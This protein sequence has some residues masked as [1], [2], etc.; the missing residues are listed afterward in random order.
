MKHSVQIYSI[1][2]AGDFDTQLALLRK[3]GFEWVE[4]VATHGLAP[5][6]FAAKLQQYGLK[7]SSMHASLGLV[8]NERAT[9]VEACKLTGCPL[10]VMPYLVNGD[11]PRSAAGWRAMGERLGVVGRAFAAE[12]IRFAYHNHDW[13]FLTYDGKYALEWL[14]DGAPAADV[15]WEMDVG[16]I[17]RAGQSPCKW[18]TQFG[19]RIVAI[20]A[21]EISPEGVAIEEDGWAPLGGG[22]APW[23]ELFPILRKRT[24]LYVFEHDNPKDFEARL[25]ESLAYMR[26]NFR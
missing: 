14:F 9:L 3:V 19:D 18:E 11:R 2:D 17:V 16:W 23:Q 22:N 10:V 1:R 24:D 8:E 26:Q 5:V 25:S 4:S 20:H 15:A 21:K 13:E 7:L 12:G 6:E